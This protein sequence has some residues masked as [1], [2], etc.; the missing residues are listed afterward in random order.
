MLLGRR[1]ALRFPL[2]LV[3]DYGGGGAFLATGL[4][5][6]MLKSH[7]TGQGDVVDAAMIDGSAY[8]MGVADGRLGTGLWH[9]KKG[10]NVLDGSA[11]WY[12]V[13]ETSDRKFVAVG[14]IES[15]FYKV[16]LE[17][18]GIAEDSLPSQEKR[19]SWSEVR[20]R[21]AQ[22][23]REKTRDK[24]EAWFEPTDACVTPVWSMRE[25]PSH[26][27]NLER[28]SFI[29]WKGIPVPAP[30]PRYATASTPHFRRSIVVGP[31]EIEREWAAKNHKSAQSIEI[32]KW[33]ALIPGNGVCDE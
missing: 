28:K 30:A 12:S 7:V 18:L 33:S 32:L 3:E 21:L 20:E 22:T 29:E 16:L 11:P 2:N 17:K 27:H 31:Q 13:Y 19:S 25:T 5:A 6:T 23:F 26:F 4:L 1:S 14:A 24:R 15:R 10:E 9:D 8:L